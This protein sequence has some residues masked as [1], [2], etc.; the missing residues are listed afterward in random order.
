MAPQTPSP[1]PTR[2]LPPRLRRVR[3]LAPLL[4]GP[5][6]L[7]AWLP[8]T[9]QAQAAPAPYVPPD[10]I[11]FRT[12]WITSA[13]SRIHAEILTSRDAPA[14]PLPTILSAHGWGGNAA[15][16]R[17]DAVD[18][19]RAGYLVVNFDYR[20]WGGSEGRLVPVRPLPE[21]RPEGPLTVEV[22]EV[23]GIIDP[24]EQVDDWF[25]VLDWAMGEARIDPARIGL[26]GTS[27][28]GGHVVYVAAH[29]PRVRAIVSQVPATDIARGMPQ[30]FAGWEA[31]ATA[32]A[33]GEAGLPEP[34]VRRFNLTGLPLGDRVVR[35]SPNEVAHR[36]RAPALF[37]VAE[38]EEL[39]TNES[40]AL[41]AYARVQGPARYV[42][43]P[44]ITHYA[45]Y[46]AAREE[47][48]RHA[49]E[50]FGEHLR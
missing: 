37:L 46:G 4:I 13:G 3:T 48:V 12:A 27:F 31:E 42:V 1:A 45:V 49:V 47:A 18:L 7:G 2:W 11:E 17:T 10:D 50:W 26:R 16:L 30:M 21:D 34:F 32:R 15:L 8:G 43:I 41:L 5:L 14:G 36:V 6:L 19:A 39:Y 24:W 9:L 29:D 25:H 28:S 38:H 44:D 33:R 22:Q 23:R 35:Y 20:G 40:Q